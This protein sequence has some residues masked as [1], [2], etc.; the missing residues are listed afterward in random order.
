[1]EFMGVALVFMGMDPPHHVIF[2]SNVRNMAI[3]YGA[4]YFHIHLQ[5]F[6]SWLYGSPTAI[7]L[8]L[9]SFYAHRVKANL[10]PNYIPTYAH[11]M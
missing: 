6:M 2:L 4:I 11:D 10:Y 3:G 7:W 5:S 1:M 8:W 9:Q